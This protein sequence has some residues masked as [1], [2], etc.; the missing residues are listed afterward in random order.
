MANT[1]AMQSRVTLVLED[2]KNI[3]V[4]RGDF[5]KI[6]DH[7]P[8]QVVE[9]A[10]LFNMPYLQGDQ[11]ARILQG[12]YNLQFEV[13]NVLQLAVGRVLN[14]QNICTHALIMRFPTIEVLLDYC[15]SEALSNI[16]AKMAPHLYGEFIVDYL[17]SVTDKLEVNGKALPEPQSG[18]KW[19]SLTFLRV[20]EAVCPGAVDRVIQSL[21]DAAEQLDYVKELTVGSNLYVRGNTFSHAFAVYVPSAEALEKL[22]KDP[23]YSA[24][25]QDQV[26]PVSSKTLSVKFLTFKP[27]L[28]AL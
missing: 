3:R 22:L 20:K 13:E 26:L 2:V 15:Q 17:A 18:L 28:S 11:E 23:C 5:K 27:V 16:T 4:I 12:L 19:I 8:R 14:Q 25:L 9:H 10:V 7:T 21:S 1:D 6:C 24:V